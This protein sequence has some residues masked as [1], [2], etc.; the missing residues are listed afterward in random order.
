[1]AAGGR[2][3]IADLRTSQG[4]HA[5]AALGEAAE[6]VESD[7]TDP[8]Q[9]QASVAAAVARGPLRG[10]VHTAGRGGPV[11]LVNKD[12]SP[13][14][15]GTYTQIIRTNLIGTFVVAS[16]AA[17]HMVDNEPL[18]GDRGAIVLTASVAAFEGQIGQA[19]YASSKAGIV[20]LT[21]CAARDLAS[22][23]VRVCTIAPGLMDTPLLAGLRQDIKDSLA[24]SVPHPARLG[25]ASEFASLALEILHNG[26]LNGETFRLDGAI[27]MAP[28]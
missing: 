26:Y 3:V 23:G 20:G 4:A 1:M 9:V 13:G 11:R 28:R 24:T 15:L 12:G 7:V 18:D 8:E 16:I 21:L 10:V 27:R 5:A 17:A 14:D 25:D 6:F 2:V 19:A 22:R